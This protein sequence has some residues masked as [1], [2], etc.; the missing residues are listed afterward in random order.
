MAETP[1]ARDGIKG[2]LARVAHGVLD[3][4]AGAMAAAGVR[5]DLLTVLGLVF[6]VASALAFFEGGFR[7]GSM[8]LA[9]A[10]LCDLLDGQVARRSGKVVI[11]GATAIDD[12]FSDQRAGKHQHIDQ[13]KQPGQQQHRTK[14]VRGDVGVE[15][16]GGHGLYHSIARHCEEPLRRSNP[17]SCVVSGLLRFARNDGVHTGR[18]FRTSQSAPPRLRCAWR[19]D[20]K[21]PCG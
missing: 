9:L 5:P 2:W 7:W 13:Q 21:I 11:D 14:L 1:A 17:G 4:V 6:S 10:G 18:P 20:R 16:I 12:D 3:P 8:L 15:T 19:R